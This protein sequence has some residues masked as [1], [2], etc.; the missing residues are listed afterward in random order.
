VKTPYLWSGTTIYARGKYAADGVF[1]PDL[2][3]AQVGAFALLIHLAEIGE[4][5]LPGVGA[6]KPDEAVRPTPAPADAA[7]S[8]GQTAPPPYPGRYLARESNG[9]E[10]ELVQRRLAALGCDPKG[11]DQDF[12][13]DTESAVK[14][15]QARSVG[16]GGEPLEIDGVVGPETWAALFGGPA[17]PASSAFVPAATSALGL[18]AI[19][20]A[21]GEIGVRETPLGS[22]RGPKVDLYMTAT[23]PGS[24]GLPW[25]M[26]FVYWCFKEAASDLGRGAP[27]PKTAGVLRGWDLAQSVPTATIVPAAAARR[28]PSLV[29]P[30]MVFYM[31]FG[32]G[33]GHTGIVV[34][35][36]NGWLT[37]IEGNS[38]A[39]G[40]REG[41]GVFLRRSRKVEQVQKGFVGFA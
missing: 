7:A 15:F 13:P 11:F 19:E 24:I 28:N 27:V 6:L 21:E 26:A 1:D 41:I 32:Q 4:I 23:S 9:A 35:N 29:A 39:E 17:A 37:T 10:V 38:N 30:G 16:R 36:V 18:K 25:C 2:V 40:G 8:S 5:A 33:A 34:D 12:G 3:S 20:I 22:N 14:M 31:D